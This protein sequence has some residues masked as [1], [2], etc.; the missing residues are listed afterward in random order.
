MT[1][2]YSLLFVHSG[3]LDFG[4]IHTLWSSVVQP[5][6]EWVQPPV[7]LSSLEFWPMGENT[8]GKHYCQVVHKNAVL[9][10]L[11]KTEI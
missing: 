1:H 4:T 2:N 5:P 8:R 9:I 11:K 6:M 10:Y 7:W 3:E